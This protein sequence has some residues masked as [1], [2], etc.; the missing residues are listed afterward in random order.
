[1]QSGGFRKVNGLRKLGSS[2][3]PAP[4]LG[5]GASITA[6]IHTPSQYQQ[7]ELRH[8]LYPGARYCMVLILLV[9]AN[10]STQ[11]GQTWQRPVTPNKLRAFSLVSFPLLYSFGEQYIP[12]P[13]SW[14]WGCPLGL[15]QQ[16]IHGCHPANRLTNLAKW[17][18]IN[19]LKSWKAIIQGLGTIQPHELSAQID[20]SGWSSWL[21]HLRDSCVLGQASVLICYTEH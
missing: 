8:Q 15:V 18:Q 1:M 21:V 4:T 17:G 11:V 20:C 3:P 14:L 2:L 16:S 5:V 6:V 10:D 9:L 13:D 12:Y 19:C 7:Q